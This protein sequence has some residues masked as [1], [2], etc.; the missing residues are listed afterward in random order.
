MISTGIQGRAIHKFHPKVKDSR[1]ATAI[2]P[3]SRARWLGRSGSKYCSIT[4]YEILTLSLVSPFPEGLLLLL[5]GR[6]LSCSD[7]L[8]FGCFPY[9]VAYIT[10]RM[11]NRRDD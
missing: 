3:I 2:P 8:S 7:W 11:L 9:I 5:L 4:S 10:R 1:A 6:P